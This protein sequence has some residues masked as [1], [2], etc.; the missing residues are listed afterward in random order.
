VGRNIDILSENRAP[1][2]GVSHG[3]RLEHEECVHYHEDEFRLVYTM[4]E[5][6]RIAQIWVEG[7]EDARK[8]GF[9]ETYHHIS[10]GQGQNLGKPCLHDNRMAAELTADGTI[11]VHLKNLRIHLKQSEFVEFADM[12]AQ[13]RVSLGARHHI[14]LNISEPLPE[15]ILIPSV[16]QHHRRAIQEYKRNQNEHQSSDDIGWLAHRIRWL[17]EHPQGNQEVEEDLQRADGRLPLVFPSTPPA[18]LDRKYAVVVYEAIRRWGFADGPF[19]GQAM[20]AY[21][22]RNGQ[23]YLKGAHR[24]AAA[25]ELGLK[26]IPVLLMDPPTG[27]GD[28]DDPK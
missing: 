23:I 9:P 11:H 20:P 2:E 12:L 21:R 16:V 7:L 17:T 22:Y 3:A 25:L 8:I 27:W 19:Y 10:L 6:R 18:D 24:T 13:A 15:H 28:P 4:E 14:L 26:E 1:T 5:F